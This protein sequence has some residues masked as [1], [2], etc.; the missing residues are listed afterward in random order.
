MQARFVEA[1]VR[2]AGG[3]RGVELHA[4][5]GYFLCQTLSP[6]VNKRTDCV[7]EAWQTGTHYHG[8]C[9]E[10]RRRCGKIF[11]AIRMNARTRKRLPKPSAC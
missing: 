3:L 5:H 10:I 2:A 4:A 8:D 1:A 6:L 11:L 9:R 7:A